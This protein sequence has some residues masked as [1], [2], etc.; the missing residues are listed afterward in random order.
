MDGSDQAIAS[1]QARQIEADVPIRLG[2]LREE[3]RGRIL[4]DLREL[5][6]QLDDLIPELEPFGRKPEPLEAFEVE[7]R[8]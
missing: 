8:N 7:Q 3:R 6:A 1:R 4:T 5:A 2:Q